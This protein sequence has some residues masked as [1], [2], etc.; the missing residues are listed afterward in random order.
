MSKSQ[1]KT[2]AYWYGDATPPLSARM[3]A[4]LYGRVVAL[5]AK[6]F[7]AGVLRS[8]Q[9]PVPVVVVGNL[10]IGGT[11]KTPLT[12]A[13]VQRLQNEGWT[14]GRGQ[15]RLWKAQRSQPLHGWKATPRRPRAA[16]NR[17]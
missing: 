7:R 15:P 6:L 3:L 17:C 1:D 9:V 5:R 2:P 8:R 4:G 11:G 16:T 13:L 10:S 12:I 14:S